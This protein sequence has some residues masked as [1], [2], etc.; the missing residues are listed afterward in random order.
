MVNIGK[1]YYLKKIIEKNLIYHLSVYQ[2]I[3]MQLSFN[4]QWL[5]WP[6]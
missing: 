4:N 1:F 3:S 2:F 6:I 5:K